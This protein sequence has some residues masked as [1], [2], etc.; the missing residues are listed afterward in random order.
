MTMSEKSE[1]REFDPHPGHTL[2]LIVLPLEQS[3]F[4][5]F[6]VQWHFIS[7]LLD[8]CTSGIDFYW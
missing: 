4:A 2:L 3:K 1:G 5:H 6:V 8:S 7:S